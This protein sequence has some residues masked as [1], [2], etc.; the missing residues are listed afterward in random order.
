MN[1]ITTIALPG[2]PK[3]PV[4]AHA[5]ELHINDLVRGGTLYPASDPGE[6]GFWLAA[7]PP[8]YHPAAPAAAVAYDRLCRA[9]D[10]VT[11]TSWLG[12][13]ASGPANAPTAAEMPLR[14]A[15]IMTACAD[16]PMGVWND[17][18][19]RQALR[20]FDWW[21]PPA[22][23]FKLL[24]PHAKRLNSTRDVLRRIVR[25]REKPPLPPPRE[26]PTP[27]ARAEVQALVATFAAER[28]YN[29]PEQAADRPRPKAQP[30]SDQQLLALYEE[31]SRKGLPGAAIRLQALR[32]KLAVQD[33]L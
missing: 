33:R 32:K 26:E 29:Q 4:L 17:E 20:E 31:S 10:R 1:Q 18:T 23:V 8:V 30:L 28:S 12:K 19:L 7:P 13:L 16:L 2:L 22:K 15:A 9:A 11:I 5:L 24:E 21:P 6:A 14:A 3:I 27:Q 25:A